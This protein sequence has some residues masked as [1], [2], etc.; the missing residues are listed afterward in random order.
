MS[1]Q[2]STTLKSYFQT[3]DQPTQQ[4][5]ADQIDTL[6]LGTPLDGGT[7]TGAA[8]VYN[9]SVDGDLTAMTV[10]Q[11]FSVISHQTNSGAATSSI[12]SIT[13]LSITKN[14]STA[15]AS[16]DIS[17][18]AAM[19]LYFDGG[20]LQLLNPSTSTSTG[21]VGSVGLSMPVEF[22]VAGSPITSSGVLAV[23]KANQNPNLV[24]AGPAIAPAAAPTMRALVAADLP[25]ATTSAQGAVQLA[26][27]AVTKAATDTTMPAAVGTLANHPGVAKAWVNFTGAGVIRD[28]YN[29]SSVTRNSTGNYTIVFNTAFSNANYCISISTQQTSGTNVS[30]TSSLSSPPTTS[31]CI[32]AAANSVNGSAVDPTISYISFL[33]SI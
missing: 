31:Q 16:G 3:G 4:Q 1:V 17:L 13:P 14:G 26:T 12:N 22:S 10:G 20:R 25:A 2:N 15:L 21:T 33:G 18:G 30:M 24:Y 6:F 7:S 19:M 11:V 8:N 32:L 27:A 5:F 29:I 9:F 28:S 23:T